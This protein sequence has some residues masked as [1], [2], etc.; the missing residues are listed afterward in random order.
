MQYKLHIILSLIVVFSTLS[1]CDDSGKSRRKSIK[2]TKVTHTKSVKQKREKNVKLTSLNV[3]EFLTKYGKQH[4]E[5]D[6]E[7][8]TKFGKMRI[9]LYKNT[10]LHRANFLY[11][12]NQKYFNGTYFHRVVSGFMIQGGNSDDWATSKK[13]AKIGSYKFPA[14]MKEKNIHKKG[15]LSAVRT[16]N[17]NPEKKTSPYEFFIVQGHTFEE[18]MLEAVLET[19]EK[20]LS[21]TNKNIYKK[22]GGTPH[23]DGEHT[24]FGEVVSGFD[25]IDK[26]S[27]VKTDGKEWPI[28]NVIMNVKIL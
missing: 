23:L 3:V 1:S 20:K 8:S 26:I 18:D 10:P 24:V 6:I 27:A 28:S 5:T 12:I 9:K 22:I 21:T 4:P 2:H 13:R 16:Y 7:L 17:D 19:Y 25:V 14:E 15:A 11:L